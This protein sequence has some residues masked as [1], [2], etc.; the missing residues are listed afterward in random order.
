V[1]VFVFLVVGWEDIFYD[2]A[3]IIDE[4]VGLSGDNG[5]LRGHRAGPAILRG[6]LL[7]FSGHNRRICGIEWR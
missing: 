6:H 7:R 2:S 5:R 3:D 4:F 1:W